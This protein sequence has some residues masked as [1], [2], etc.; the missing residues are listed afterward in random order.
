MIAYSIINT[1]F[2]INLCKHKKQYIIAVKKIGIQLDYKYGFISLQFYNNQRYCHL[3]LNFITKHSQV[4]IIG[5]DHNNH[6]MQSVLLL[7]CN[8]YEDSI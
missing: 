1:F 3:C 6:N 2:E 8:D 4:S 5:M 7:L